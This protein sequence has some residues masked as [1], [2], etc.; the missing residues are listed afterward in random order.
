MHTLL[1]VAMIHRD[2][3]SSLAAAASMVSTSS[4]CPIRRKSYLEERTPAPYEAPEVLGNPRLELW[5]GG[6]I[7]VSAHAP[8]EGPRK[9]Q[10][11]ESANIRIRRIESLGRIEDAPF[12]VRMGFGT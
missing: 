8:D 2:R 9:D 10:P 6:V 4:R 7:D 3:S 1:V 5:S 12:L 11:Q